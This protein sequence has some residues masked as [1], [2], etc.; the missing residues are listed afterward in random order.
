MALVNFKN[1]ILLRVYSVALVVIVVA[2]VIFVKAFKLV[3]VEGAHWRAEAAKRF[4]AYREVQGDRGNI[5]S[6]DG[7]LL[8]TSIPYFDLYWDAE[9]CKNYMSDEDSTKGLDSLAFYLGYYIAPDATP[10]QWKQYL[11]EQLNKKARYAP[12]AKRLTYDTMMLVKRFPIFN[13]KNKTKSGLIVIKNDKRTHPFRMLALRSLGYVKEKEDIGE[14][15]DLKVGLE[16][17]FHK[18]LTGETEKVLMQ[19]VGNDMWAPVENLSDI[20]PP[21]ASDLLTTLDV[22]IQDITQNALLRSLNAHQAEH[23]TAIVMEVKTGKIKAIANIGMTGEGYWEDYN[24]GIGMSIEPGSTMKLLSFM[25]LLEDKLIKLSDTVD[26]ENGSTKFFNETLD[27]A[28]RINQRYITVKEVFA[29]SSNVGTSK[30]A[31]KAYQDH[32]QTFVK[33]LKDF[34]MTVP[35]GI[36]IEGE[37]NPYI[38]NPDSSTDNWS[39][40]TVPW[41]SI[42]Y[43]LKLTP[44]QILTFYNAVAN[45]GIM[46]KPYLVNEIQRYGVTQKVFRPTQIKKQIASNQTLEQARELLEAVVE[47]G[48]AKHL[49]TNQYRFAGKTGTAQLNYEKLSK[50]KQKIGGHQGSF[51]GYFPAENPIYSCIVVV[52]KPKVGSFYGGAVAAPVFRE[53]ADRLMSSNVALSEPINQ[54]GKPV[55]SAATLPDDV[56]FKNDM[57]KALTGFKMKYEID[58][59]D[60]DWTSLRAKGDTVHLAPRNILG[61]KAIPSVVGMGLKDAL[62]LLENRGLKVQFSGYGK[63]VSQSLT[64]GQPVVGQVISIKLD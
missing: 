31:F 14:T 5:L 59:K 25:S 21:N 45:N 19:K 49:R 44:L 22:N 35:T 27:D 56:G 39:G 51:V 53:I 58:S 40:T 47:F 16:G 4:M 57:V 1:E 61:K 26:I 17:R 15:Q 7:S 60:D 52:H 29:H 64:P 13:K 11:W 30:L 20:A 2:L 23:G 41:M 34:M 54:R 38:K 50:T 37:G 48:T 46:M 43:E 24:Y 62:Y 63:V 33:H 12:I 18:E 55:A 32:P 3:T 36:E 8:A 28:E 9:T 6:E 42:G 10:G